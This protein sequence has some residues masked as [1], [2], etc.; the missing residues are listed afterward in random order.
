MKKGFCLLALSLPVLFFSCRKKYDY[1]NLVTPDVLL[2]QDEKSLA[3]I[4]SLAGSKSLSPDYPLDAE[5]CT[6]LV[7]EIRSLPSTAIS[8]DLSKCKVPD[9]EK[10]GSALPPA[11]FSGLSN[12]VSAVLPDGLETISENLF[13]DCVS[14]KSIVIPDSVEAI[15]GRAFSGCMSLEK[16][17]APEKGILIFSYQGDGL[18][19]PDG[20]CPYKNASVIR[21]KN[22]TSY[23][24][25]Y[26]DCWKYSKSVEAGPVTFSEIWASSFQEG[27][28]P[29]NLS[30]G[31]WRTWFENE[32][33][34]GED[35]KI[36]MSFTRENTI[37]TVTFR[38][39]NGNTE[40]FWSSNRV[41]D[42]EIYF[43]D[44]KSPELITLKDSM[45]PQTYRFLYGKRRKKRYVKITFV[46]KSVYP[47]GKGNETCISEISINDADRT[48]K[49][50][51]LTEKIESAFSSYE[52]G[53]FE[54]GEG[55]LEKK[56][57]REE[58]KEPF[59][60]A[61]DRKNP[62]EAHFL[63][64]DG[65]SWRKAPSDAARSVRDAENDCLMAGKIPRFSL[66]SDGDGFD[67][68][69]Q[70][71]R[72]VEGFEDADYGRPCEF[73]FSG[74][75][76]KMTSGTDLT[77]K[78]IEVE[79]RDFFP[80]LMSLDPHGLYRID[81][82]GKL[83]AEFFRHLRSLLSPDGKISRERNFILNMWNC[84]L[85]EELQGCIG[86]DSISGYFIQII[87]PSCTK[88][89]RRGS[90]TVAADLITIPAGINK[91]E[92]GAFV[93]GKGSSFD[94]YPNHV[95]FDGGDPKNYTVR[96]NLLL[97]SIPESGGEKRLLLYM[98]Q[99]KKILAG[100]STVPPEDIVIPDDVTELAPYSLYAADVSSIV[101]P[102][103]FSVAGEKSMD[104]MKVRKMDLSKCDV[105]SLTLETIRE[106]GK[107]A[108]SNPKMDMEG[109][110]FCISVSGKMT[111]ALT[112]KIENEIRKKK[113]KKVFLDLSATS[114]EWNE[115]AG[116]YVPLPD[117]FLHD[118][119]NLVWLSL[120]R[121]NYIPSN[122]CRD[123]GNLMWVEFLQEPE[124]ISEPAFKGC[125]AG[126]RAVINGEKK[127]L[128]EYARSKRF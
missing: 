37:S 73:N 102:E 60:L 33:G 111:S 38:N 10:F 19:Y 29:A 113:E 84:T 94:V 32:R 48:F 110:L 114:L 91:I 56:I 18:E 118:N 2:S 57:W 1:G 25:W 44:E 15:E 42:V 20:R 116:K 67:L 59:A 104:L 8:L 81:L 68:S 14:L 24:K 92:S 23:E 101:F 127:D 83:D 96:G 30:D 58:G 98:G 99:P 64:F 88:V 63:V 62:R 35:T 121:Y 53:L 100:E 80:T 69:L 86:E 4:P 47:G 119:Q 107:V 3:E 54:D 76:F 66:G 28:G 120:G 106:F 43:G 72:H 115:D 112:E 124:K 17:T 103:G 109:N 87:L 45:E 125:R 31:S 46:I 97:E 12:I 117:F 6:R 26:M 122:M 95:S 40:N 79:A 52:E 49:S 61:I 70:M 89:L 123:C 108:S 90:V 16:I 51:S 21:G 74:G 65:K 11:L 22:A 85:S 5:G 7:S 75:R 39:G 13:A 27:Y 41:R 105:E 71:T 82:Y 36:V 9:D 128:W 55:H 93:S 50:D 77:L 78:K 126:A 34:A